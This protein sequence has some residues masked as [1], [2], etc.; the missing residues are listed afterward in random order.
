M[1]FCDSGPTHISLNLFKKF[2]K[3]IL[4]MDNDLKT[5]IPFLSLENYTENNI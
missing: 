1:G 3:S 4:F 5:L 2:S